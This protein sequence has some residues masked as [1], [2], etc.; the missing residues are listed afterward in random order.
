MPR[1]KTTEGIQARNLVMAALTSGRAAGMFFE[2]MGSSRSA[3]GLYRRW[4][5]ELV[6]DLLGWAWVPKGD[7]YL[8]PAVVA[9]VTDPTGRERVALLFVADAPGGWAVELK[10]RP[11]VEPGLL[12]EAFEAPSAPQ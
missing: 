12:Q 1:I 3:R 9:R 8:W 5:I 7:A 2:F 11:D 10:S 4:G 6:V